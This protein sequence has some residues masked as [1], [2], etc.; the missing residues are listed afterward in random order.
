MVNFSLESLKVCYAK[1][2]GCDCEEDQMTREFGNPAEMDF[3]EKTPE[4]L[5]KMS[6]NELREYGRTKAEAYGSTIH[7]KFFV[8]HDL[9]RFTRVDHVQLGQPKGFL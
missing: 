6:I 3:V 4:D 1:F 8:P 9:S 7:R 5:T 2:V